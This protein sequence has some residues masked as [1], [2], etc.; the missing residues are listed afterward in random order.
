MVGVLRGEDVAGGGGRGRG[1]VGLHLRGGF[2]TDVFEGEW[3]EI[4]NQ[5]FR[6][7]E[8]LDAPADLNREEGDTV[9][10]NPF[11]PVNGPVIIL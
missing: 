4:P 9:T 11:E 10:P 1:D 3:R 6:R 2:G 5:P 7:F 8:N